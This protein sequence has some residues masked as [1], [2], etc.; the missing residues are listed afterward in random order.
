MGR[1]KSEGK[2]ESIGNRGG[3]GGDNQVTKDNEESPK[4][5]LQNREEGN[6]REELKAIKSFKK[7]GCYL[8]QKQK[9]EGRARSLLDLARKRKVVGRN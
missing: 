4:R 7:K 2:S 6:G 8:S 5:K 3:K 1:P 9:N